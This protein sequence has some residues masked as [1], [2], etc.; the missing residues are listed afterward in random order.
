MS[1]SKLSACV[2][3]TRALDDID[4]SDTL[5]THSRSSSRVRFGSVGCCYSAVNDCTSAGA[6]MI[7]AVCTCYTDKASTN[8]PLPY[9]KWTIWYEQ[10][11]CASYK[12]KNG[13]EPVFKLLC[14][15]TTCSIRI[16][17]DVKD[18]ACEKVALKLAHCYT[19]VYLHFHSGLM[20]QTAA[21]VYAVYTL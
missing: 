4:I 15:H 3:S 13:P 19:A 18:G 8:T 7:L 12:A 2:P 5:V 16:L 6:T 9:S 21:A 14:A 1:Y 20:Q 10:Y 11:A 17:Q